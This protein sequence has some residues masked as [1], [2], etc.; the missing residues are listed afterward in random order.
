[1]LDPES[2]GTVF[3]RNTGKHSPT[4]M[5][6]H[7]RRLE[8][9]LWASVPGRGRWCFHFLKQPYRFWNLPIA[10]SL[11]DISSFPP[12]VKWLGHVPACTA[13][14][15]NGWSYA[16]TPVS[17]YGV[18]R[19]NLTFTM[20]SLCSCLSP[21]LCTLS[22]VTRNTFGQS[23]V[24]SVTF[25]VTWKEQ[26]A[27]FDNFTAML[28]KVPVLWDVMLHHWVSLTFLWVS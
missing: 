20:T 11:V 8:Y 22:A 7:P 13:E 19:E 18:H 21:S 4:D 6:S 12:V 26:L 3:F 5:V 23:E 14:V 27:M 15:K 17:L 2:G 25:V 28:Q 16:A 1:V 24:L 10:V 9:S